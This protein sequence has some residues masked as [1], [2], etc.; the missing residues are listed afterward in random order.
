MQ[1][2]HRF[3]G[4]II[5]LDEPQN[6]NMEMCFTVLLLGNAMSLNRNLAI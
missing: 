5:P 3:Y 6:S 4:F 1:V 2:G